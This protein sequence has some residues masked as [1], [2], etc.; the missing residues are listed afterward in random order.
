MSRT[1]S[2]IPCDD[3]SRSL[4]LFETLLDSHSKSFCGVSTTLDVH[5]AYGYA[6]KVFG[7]NNKFRGD[8][9]VSSS[10]ALFRERTVLERA[11]R[12]KRG[13]EEENQV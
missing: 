11:M 4:Y 5:N 12:I 7:A 13:R 1:A 6:V 8:V 9:L 10:F 3:L 2:S